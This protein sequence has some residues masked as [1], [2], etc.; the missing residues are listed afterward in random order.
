MTLLAHSGGGGST[1]STLPSLEGMSL[2]LGS[3]S[4]ENLLLSDELPSDQGE[5]P[6]VPSP[7]SPTSPYAAEEPK[8]PPRATTNIAQFL[9]KRG[10]EVKQINETKSLQPPSLSNTGYGQSM[11]GHDVCVGVRVS[12]W[13]E[14]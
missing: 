13:H 8:E 14:Q 11:H 3:G 1:A 10:T 9:Q 4:D 7:T 12:I 5:E 2:S 6:E